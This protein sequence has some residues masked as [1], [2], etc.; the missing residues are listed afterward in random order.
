MNTILINTKNQLEFVLAEGIK[1][2]DIDNFCDTHKVELYWHSAESLMSL[3]GSDLTAL[4][5]STQADDRQ[6]KKFADKKSAVA[7]IMTV[8]ETIPPL[9]AT[10]L[11]AIIGDNKPAVVKVNPITDADSSVATPA[12]EDVARE[13]AVKPA[14]VKKETEGTT[15]AN[16][17]E[18]MI[19]H[20]TEETL[21]TKELADRYGVS[22]KSIGTDL[23][24]IR[25]TGNL[26]EIKRDADETTRGG[27]TYF[28]SE[29]KVNEEF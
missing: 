5:N 3:S 8:I 19:R 11:K 27:K 6:V 25:K 4:Y 22:T 18:A 16:R 29:E 17:R 7:R 13:K 20:L 10:E 24:H 2:Y 21:S 12:A 28:Y 23:F 15:G 1:N 9:T 26:Y 14:K